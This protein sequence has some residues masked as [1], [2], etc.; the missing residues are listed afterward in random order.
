[1]KRQ[2][3]K[4]DFFEKLNSR[5][6]QIALLFEYTADICFFIKD[7]KGRFITGNLALAEKIKGCKN[8]DGVI[9]LTDGD[10]FPEEL[11]SHYRRCDEA[12]IATGEPM[13]NRVEMVPNRDGTVEWHVT[14]KIPLVSEQGEIVGL[15]GITQSLHKLGDTWKPYHQMGEIVDYITEHYNTHIEVR[16]MAAISHLS[17]SQFE[18]VFRQTFGVPPIR[19]INNF[20][21]HMACAA[22]RKSNK[23]IV[24]IALDCGF[25]DHSHFSREFVRVMGKS[26][27][28]YRKSH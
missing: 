23:T 24:C 6:F 16:D 19:L 7:I 10:V 8:S 3:L 27:G 20:R 21:V 26:P 11:A 1:M 2:Q 18:R 25:Y 5:T 9:G 28:E 15:A 17:V 4:R 12:I 22:L 13:I 14:T